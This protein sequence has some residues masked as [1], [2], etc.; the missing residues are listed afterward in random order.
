[1]SELVSPFW[2]VISIVQKLV[3]A[4]AERVKTVS[5]FNLQWS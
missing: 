3:E 5:L 4:K 2:T 1:M